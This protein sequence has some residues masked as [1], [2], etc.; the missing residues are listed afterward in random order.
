MRL[1]QLAMRELARRKIRTLYTA[2]S[3]T[4]SV[5]LLTATVVGAA[6]Q[7][8][9]M[10]IIARYGHSLTIF[11]ATSNEVTLQN[12]GIGTG[13]YIPEASIPEIQRVYEAAIRTGWQKRGAL[14]INDGTPGGISDLEPAM[15]MPR[16]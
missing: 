8:D 9:L 10:L 14:I 16:L 2:S 13:H 3:I 1:Y 11:P 15:F 4:L 6:G 7:R 12:F 5:A